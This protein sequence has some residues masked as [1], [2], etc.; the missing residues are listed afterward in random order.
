MASPLDVLKEKIGQEIGVSDW[1]LID[2]AR[3]DAFAAAT[4][5][6]QWIHV[7]AEKSAAGP[8]GATVAHGFL[9][10]SLLPRLTGAQWREGIEMKHGLNYG[11]EKVR[12]LT[13]VRA[14]S[15]IRNRLRLL[16]AVPRGEAGT[17]LSFENHVE[18][19]GAAKPALIAITLVLAV[20]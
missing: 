7:D 12:F 5:D 2:Q 20:H 4:E 16:S 9:T 6:F 17:L 18:I 8:F 13:P 10:L 19:E 11:L 1:L 14:G 15:R 3:I